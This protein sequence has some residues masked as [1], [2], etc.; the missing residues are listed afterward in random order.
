MKRSDSEGRRSDIPS[1][2]RRLAAWRFWRRD[3]LEP[4]GLEER[5]QAQTPIPPEAKP[6]PLP[7]PDDRSAPPPSRPP[8]QEWNLWE[9]ERRAREQAGDSARDEEWS[10]LF[11]NLRQFADAE[12]ILPKEFDDLIR[13]SFSELIKAA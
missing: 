12:G 10:A 1:P 13:E 3:R 9:L 11:L 4:P 7:P 5:E 6:S 8:A 2:R